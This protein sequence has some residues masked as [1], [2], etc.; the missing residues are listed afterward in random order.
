[1]TKLMS[2]MLT[3]ESTLHLPASPLG[4]SLTLPGRWGA[5]CKLNIMP[6]EWESAQRSEEDP[7]GPSLVGA[8]PALHF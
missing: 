7:R 3:L 5:L 2:E 4:W 6:V 1:M 8:A